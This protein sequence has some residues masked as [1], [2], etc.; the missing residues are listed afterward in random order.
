MADPAAD[1]G[2]WREAAAWL[3][4]LLIPLIGVIRKQ[5]AQRADAQDKRMDFIEEALQEK[6][7][8]QELNRQRNNIDKLFD[9]QRQ[10]EQT[11]SRGFQD[12]LTAQHK[13][14]TALLD[15]LSDK[16]DKP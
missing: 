5:A 10:I 7:D 3:W 8:E 13:M 1:P 15:K 4:A 12:V 14:H 11:M 9:G 16:V 6:A 2:L